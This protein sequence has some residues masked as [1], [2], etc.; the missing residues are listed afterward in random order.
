MSAMGQKRT[1]ASLFDYRI[2]VSGGRSQLERGALG[3]DENGLP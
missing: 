3:S 2:L 1:S